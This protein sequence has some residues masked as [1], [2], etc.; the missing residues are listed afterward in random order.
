MT[1]VTSQVLEAAPVEVQKHLASVTAPARAFGLDALRGLAIIGMVFS[2]VFPHESP[3][4]GWM[5]HAQVGPPD[6]TYTPTV[7][8]ITW[9]DLVFPFFLFSM[10]A[11]FPLAM[12]RKIGQGQTGEV[13]LNVLKRGALL[14][15]FAIVIRNLNWFGLQGPGWVNQLTSLITFAC[16]FL[17]FMRFTSLKGSQEV[18]V[19][20]IGFIVIAGLVWAHDS[21]TAF[22]FSKSNNDI[23]IVVLANMA[24]VGSVIW[25]L[26]RG[27]ILLRMGVL[28]LFAAVWLTHEIEGSWTSAIYNF[29]PSLNWM[30]QFRFLK[31]LC[32]VLPGSILGD[33]MLKYRTVGETTGKGSISKLL[34]G[35][36]CLAL[37][38]INL[39]GLYTRQIY[40]TLA[41][42][43]VLCLVGFCLLHKTITKQEQLWRQVFGW[44]VF[45]LWL[46]LAFE[47]LEGGIKKDPS[48]FSYWF[49]TS[50]LAF[51]TYILCDILS[52]RFHKNLFWKSII[53]SG[54]NPMVAYV[55]TAFLV[56]PLLALTHFSEVLE[57]LREINV[58]LGIVKAFVIAGLVVAVTVYTTR[59][60]WFWRT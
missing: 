16:F 1:V 25:L 9:V 53:Q 54:Q 12:S 15:F 26:T 38:I 39:Y 58:Y 50:G 45:L 32:I 14:V 43:A 57:T 51:F 30:Y 46:G 35:S 34:L 18:L 37:V 28:A 40:L 47:P 52:Q 59:K 33:L 3:W 13:L 7:P 60:G 27:N 49:L 36:L 23:I 11:A 20:L 24:V 21:F 8:G 17:V 6:F 31:Y 5:F 44:G 22:E 19:K 56:S 48:S 4:P 55:G 41:V 2:G 29:H 42:D 10:G